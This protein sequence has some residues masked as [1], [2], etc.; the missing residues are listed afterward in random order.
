MIKF[1]QVAVIG[2]GVMGSGIAAHLANC[3]INVTLFDISAKGES[4][5]NAIPKNAIS[6]IRNSII[7][8]DEA[9][10]R[11]SYANLEDDLSKLSSM[12]WVIEV[13]VEKLEIKHNLYHTIVPYL[14]E[15]T[16]LSSNT[17]TISRKL[18]SQNLPANIAKNFYIT[19]FFNPP[20]YMSL[21]ELVSDKNQEINSSL[22]F[23]I[24]QT[25]GKDIVYCKDTPGFIANRIGCY[26]LEF[27]SRRAKEMNIDIEQADIILGKPFGVPKTG[28]FGLFDLIGIDVMSLISKSLTSALDKN[29]P[30]CKAVSQNHI[31]D[32]MIE[33]NLLGRKSKQGFYKKTANGMEIYNLKTQQYAPSTKFSLPKE[34]KNLRHILENRHENSLCQYAYE[35]FRELLLY[36]ISIRDEIANDFYSIDQAMKNGYAW[37]YGIFE[38]VDILLSSND[39]TGVQMLRRILQADQVTIPDILNEIEYFYLN[40][41]LV[42]QYLQNDGQYKQYIL[43]EGFVSLKHISANLSSKLLENDSAIVRNLGDGV[44][45][46]DLKNKMNIFD[47]NVLNLLSET[48]NIIENNS[49]YK[50]L[51]IGNDDVVFSAGANIGLFLEYITT[52]QEHKLDELLQVGQE[53]FCKLKYAKFPTVLALKNIALGGSCELLLHARNAVGYLESYPGLV[54]TRIGVIPGWGGTKEMLIRTIKANDVNIAYKILDNIATA[55][56]ASSVYNAIDMNVIASNTPI[57]RNKNF[58]LTEGKKYVKKLAQ[59]YSA[60]DQDTS[61]DIP[62][63]IHE[64]I[65]KHR[66]NYKGSEHDKVINESLYRIFSANGHDVTS[67][68]ELLRLER[69]EFIRLMQTEKTQARISHTLNTGK[70]LKN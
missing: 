57:V 14:S 15:D 28:V 32:D 54:E 4:D 36:T 62:S 41:N 56:T 70:P 47:T 35:V 8:N 5:K 44:L 13:I 34:Y 42:P 10:A 55:K 63:Y 53:T 29:D 1:S 6:K 39:E 60:P 25:L 38:A 3:G 21:L 26:W 31:Y 48:V 50:G 2:S 27:A 33:N 9:F 69:D 67:E 51:V 45:C 20:R 30:F 16:I 40:N 24:E 59:S 11:I 66:D 64:A 7:Y 18:L 49:Q 65:E 46:F 68:E 12:E 22:L 52:N 58:L 61:I 17:S 43:P 37:K 19:H 23:T